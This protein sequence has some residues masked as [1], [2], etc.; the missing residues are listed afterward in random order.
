MS[1][2]SKHN[3]VAEPATADEPTDKTVIRVRRGALRR[4]DQLKQKGAELPVAI[5]WDRRTDERR[6][7]S[8]DAGSERRKTERRQAPPF[9]WDVADFVV[10]GD[11]SRAAEGKP[12]GKKRAKKGDD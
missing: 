2:K 5:K 12:A 11:S 9:T 7:S 8:G 10:V 4:F 3:V 6:A 1:S